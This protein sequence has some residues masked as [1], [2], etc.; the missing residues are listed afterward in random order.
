VVLVGASRVYLGVHW[1]T[2]VLGGLTLSTAIVCGL[3]ALT[4]APSAA[5]SDGPDASG[6]AH[7]PSVLGTRT[8]DRLEATRVT[9]T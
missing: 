3:A 5:S 7:P 8:D 9:Q 2:D 4:V 6:G 1:L